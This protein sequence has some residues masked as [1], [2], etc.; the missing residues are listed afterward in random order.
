M[1][2]AFILSNT[3]FSPTNGVVSQAKTWKKGLE[4][5]GHKVILINMWEQNDWKSFDVIHFFNFSEYMA[6]FIGLLYPINPNIVLSPI[7]DPDYSTMALKLY[8]HWGS[9]K[10]RLTNP[11]YKL[12][13]IKHLIKTYFVRSEFEKEYMAKGF[14]IEPSHCCIVPLSYGIQPP[15]ILIEKEPFCLHISLLLDKRKN[16]KRLIDAA[17]KYQFKLV[18]AGKL[19]DEQE[20]TTLSQWLQ[21]TNTVEYRG[22]ISDEEMKNLYSKA[23][24]F[25]LP[26]IN[27]GVGI[28]ALEAAAFGCDIVVTKLGGPKEYYADMAATINP[29]SVDEIGKAVKRYI[30]GDTHQP[31]LQQY[32]QKQYSLSSV[33]GQLVYA[34]KKLQN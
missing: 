18:L 34:Y 27:E 13:T 15:D 3:V 22:Y 31:Q 30:D 1:K 9:Q 8:S 10:L 20:Q 29:Y 7:L 21:G 25:A 19:R 5:L 17:D 24:V 12:R 32:I 6:G 2:I 26:S 11:F 4:D 14:D 28:V 16:V 23:K 33:C